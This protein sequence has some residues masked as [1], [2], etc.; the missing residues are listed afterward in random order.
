MTIS[1]AKRTGPLPNMRRF[2]AA[3]VTFAAT[4]YA[5]SSLFPSRNLRPRAHF[6]S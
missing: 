2:T 6:A 5:Q 3:N 4:I 1:P